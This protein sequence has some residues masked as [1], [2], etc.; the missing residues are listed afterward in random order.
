MGFDRTKLGDGDGVSA[1]QV[2]I[3]VPIATRRRLGHVRLLYMGKE[4]RKDRE[5][6]ARF[7]IS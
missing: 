2:H 6:V 7:Y 3:E 5:E 1:L 4:A